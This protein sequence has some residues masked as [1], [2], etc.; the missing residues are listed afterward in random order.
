MS[1]L[2]HTSRSF[3]VTFPAEYHPA[4]D[5]F[6]RKTEIYSNM[7]DLEIGVKLLR[8]LYLKPRGHLSKDRLREDVEFLVNSA[9]ETDLTN[10]QAIE[11]LETMIRHIKAGFVGE[12]A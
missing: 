11:V 10:D 4:T 2:D 9:T 7:E 5:C 8:D 6:T 3:Q 12:P 1:D